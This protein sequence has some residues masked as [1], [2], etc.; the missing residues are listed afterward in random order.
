MRGIVRGSAYVP[1][2]PE[3]GGARAEWDED[4]FT[5][6]AT[7]IERL[8]DPQGEI[9]VPARLLLV[10]DLPPSAEA[11][12][13]RFLGVAIPVERCGNGPTGVR[14]AFERASESPPESGPALLVAVDLAGDRPE[15]SL[16]SAAGAGDAAVAVWIDEGGLPFSERPDLRSPAESPA[17]STGALFALARADAE[18]DLDGWRGERAGPSAAE[19]GEGPSSGGRPMLRPNEPVSQGAYVPAP[20]Y[21][22]NLPSRW[23]FAADRCGR[24]GALTFPSRGRCRE[25]GARGGFTTVHLPPDGA[26]VVASTVIGS[27]GQ[28]TEFDDQVSS[29]GPYAVVLVELAAG[30]R[31]TLQMTGTASG[32]IPVGTRVSTRLRRLYPMEGDWRYGRKALPFA[33]PS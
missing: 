26:T 14:A 12:L 30:V 22:E 24:C 10:G 9:P 13:P 27:G 20:R 8:A 31:V 28:P 17:G 21:V 15:D 18:R 6:A 5:L 11:N 1:R 4:G 7:A 29:R 16:A 33:A 2:D 3:T 19:R 23:R 32:P 25:C